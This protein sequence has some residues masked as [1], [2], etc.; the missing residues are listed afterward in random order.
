MYGIFEQHDQLSSKSSSPILDQV[1]SQPAGT[2][3]LLDVMSSQP[4]SP[5]NF[6]TS[7]DTDRAALL[8]DSDPP[9]PPSSVS[10]EVD[11]NV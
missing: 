10:Y 9:V 11:P 5:I 3:W 6:S 1:F 8:G 7:F 2:P 4:L